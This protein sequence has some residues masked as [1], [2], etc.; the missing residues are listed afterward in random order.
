[1]ARDE[2]TLREKIAYGYADF[3]FGI[4]FSFIG[5]YLFP[6]LAHK[7]AVG[8]S[9]AAAVLLVGKAWDA[10]T[11]PLI[12]ALSD[13]THSRW[14]R[15]RPWLLLGAVPFGLSFIAIWL[16]PIEFGKWDA[17]AFA[18]VVYLLHATAYTCVAVPHASLTPELT[19]DYD[20]RTGLTSYRMVF[21]I[22]GV[23]VGSVLPPRLVGGEMAHWTQAGFARA[24]AICAIV[25]V[26]G[27]LVVFLG[28][29]ERHP[30]RVVRRVSMLEGFRLVLHNRPFFLA[31]SMY[32][33][34]W[35]ALSMTTGMFVIYFNA[36]LR[37]A[38]VLDYVLLATFITAAVMLPVWVHVSARLGKRAAY[39]LG[40]SIY[41]AVGLGTLA[42]RPSAPEQV[43]IFAVGAGIGISAI[44]VLPWAI[45]PD[46]IEYDEL[47]TG[48]RREGTFYGFVTFAQKLAAAAGI[49]L[50]G[51]RL[52]LL[53]YNPSA[54]TP[55]LTV[56][57]AI[58]LLFG[59]VPACVALLGIFA[60]LFYP[61]T[62]TRHEEIRAALRA[63]SGQANDH[64]DGGTEP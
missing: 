61:I 16:L 40:M 29:R 63:R 25:M 36:W 32:L 34:A 5:L 54:P 2:L 44:Y 6:Y 38:R 41:A 52:G 37:Y 43:W 42:L 7:T 59:P 4:A 3:G 9:L 22:L 23:M 27:P 48:M 35:V 56:L 64:T 8:V 28:C 26:T 58:R 46:C 50:I 12:G 55:R 53:D 20:A 15:R 49:F 57:W 24:A 11:D 13:R 30:E 10:V 62:K 60:A 1:M 21:S 47:K 45:V 39:I 14:G 31:L 19:R 51:T 17:F 18:S 33:A